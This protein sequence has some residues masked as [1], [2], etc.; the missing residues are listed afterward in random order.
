MARRSV[1]A[2]TSGAQIVG[3][4]VD[5]G[6]LAAKAA[7]RAMPQAPPS[8]AR[9]RRKPGCRWRRPGTLADFGGL[10][11]AAVGSLSSSGRSRPAAGCPCRSE[12][13]QCGEQ[14]CAHEV[15]EGETAL[16]GAQEQRASLVKAGDGFAG[17]VVVGHDAATFRFAIQPGGRAGPR[18]S[19]TLSTSLPSAERIPEEIDPGVE[20]GGAVVAVHHRHGVAGRGDHQVD[21]AVPRQGCFRARPWRRCRCRR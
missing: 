8:A 15:G 6:L 3:Q 5:G 13:A 10:E 16:G 4:G 9:L 17:L 14:M 19:S 21:L 11:Q 18:T 20:L 1:P 12:R 7:R 2:K